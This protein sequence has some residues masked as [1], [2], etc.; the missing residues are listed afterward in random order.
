M[1]SKRKRIYRGFAGVFLALLV[2]CQLTAGIAQAWTGKV[3]ELLGIT[4]DTFAKSGNPNDYR[5]RSDYENGSALI[6]AEIALNTRLAAEGTVVLKGAPA[7]GGTRVSL[8]GMRSGAKMQFGGS[9]GELIDASNVVTLA[10]ALTS[11]GFEVN[12]NL[13]QFYQEKEA[14]YAP[15]RSSGGNIVS[16]Y[17]D[18]NGEYSQGSEIGEVP[19]NEYDP[20]LVGDYKDA[21]V[22]VFGRDAGESACF[23]PGLYG[24]KNPD[25]FTKSPTG[26]ILSLSNDERD[27]LNWV[28]AQGFRQVIVML[29]SSG[30]ME[31]EEL[32]QDPAVNCLMWIGNPGAYGTYGIAQLLKGEVL[33]SGHLP[34]TF[35][36]NTA[37]S[38]AAQNVGIFTF[39][40][41]EAIETTNNHAL[42]AEWYLVEA[43]GIYT[44][45]KYYETRY[46][47]SALGQGNASKALNGESVQPGV[48]D[49]E[50]EVS[51]PFGYGVEGSTFTE[52]ITAAD[53]DWSGERESSVTVH[54]T[55]TG[56]VAAK[57][58]VQLYVSA[59]YTQ[60]DRDQG[61][62]KA[63]VQ[64]LGYAKTVETQEKTFA[65][66]ALLQP[67]ASEDVTITFNA[68]DFYSYD[69]SYSHDGI[70]GAWVREAGDYWFATGN[71][72]HEAVNS[73]LNGMTGSS[74]P[75]TGIA[76]SVALNTDTYLTRAHDTL[77]QNQLD[78]ADLNTW[79]TDAQVT[80]LTRNDWANTFPKP[81]ESITATGEMIYALRNVTYSQDLENSLYTGPTSFTYSSGGTRKAVELIGLDYN[82][83]LY[84]TIL[85][86]MSLEELVNQYLAILQELPSIS[87]PKE[88]PSDSPLG[89]IG[90]IGQRSA[91]SIYEVAQDDPAYRHFTDVYV[92]SPVVAAT[93]SP[94]LQYEMGRLIA[95]D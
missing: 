47:D 90:Y 4:D 56:A 73:V 28:K 18:E 80:W 66:V 58:A 48:W 93:F 44:G 17:V 2:I 81:V 74:L 78:D 59:P 34:D 29:N 79:H 38:P 41:P 1:R 3:N 43:E 32:R 5:F 85:D 57:H 21:A 64:L 33:P 14:D 37:L 65:D 62:E 51:Y 42:R 15:A 88:S 27:L 52:E 71:G 16:A 72:A 8:F 94:L 87:M 91:G 55:N 9:M 54:V 70:R 76:H 63:A 35:A 40:N 45:Y 50:R 46:F 12:P 86:Q 75:T 82:D 53:I 10:D 11:R 49:Y 13:I 89:I 92:G 6:D 77:V 19:V 68:Q 67:G 26:N 83:P 95:N 60:L 36:V 7:V 69:R 61:I 39:S 84:D 24:T 31:V 25:E 22:V 23:Y 30:A 20:S